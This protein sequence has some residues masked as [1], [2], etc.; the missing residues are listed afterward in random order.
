M[1]NEAFPWLVF[2]VEICNPHGGKVIAMVEALHCR[3]KGRGQRTTMPAG[4]PALYHGIR[5]CGAVGLCR[6]IQEKEVSGKFSMK[7]AA[8]CSQVF[9]APSGFG[10]DA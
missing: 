1:G 3:K 5:Y 6:I 8:E 9:S 2:G 10:T 7:V 4:L